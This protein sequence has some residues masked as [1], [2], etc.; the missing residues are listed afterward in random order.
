M[1]KRR[2]KQDELIQIY[3]AVYN[4]IEETHKELTVSSLNLR[5][6]FFIVDNV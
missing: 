2:C 6:H 4:L 3:I 1:L 5:N